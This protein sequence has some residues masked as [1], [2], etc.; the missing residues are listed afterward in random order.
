LKSEQFFKLEK[1][2]KPNNNEETRELLTKDKQGLPL[3]R[4]KETLGIEDELKV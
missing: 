4:G 2:E 3:E 1:S